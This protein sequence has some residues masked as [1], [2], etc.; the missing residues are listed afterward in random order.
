MTDSPS[1]CVLGGCEGGGP[2]PPPP[3]PRLRMGSD[4]GRR[5]DTETQ[6]PLPG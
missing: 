4:S 2:D 3:T 6:F 5:L 1:V